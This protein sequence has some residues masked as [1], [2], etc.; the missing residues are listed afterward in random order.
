MFRAQWMFELAPGVSSSGLEPPPCKASSK[1]P[2]VKSVDARRKQEIAKEEKVQS[3]KCVIWGFLCVC[4][5]A[6]QYNCHKS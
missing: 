1:G 6:L 4:V 2:G 3:R 5:L